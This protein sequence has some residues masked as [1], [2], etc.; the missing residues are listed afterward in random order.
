M[1]TQTPGTGSPTSRAAAGPVPP[2]PG[3][4]AA[5]LCAT[6]GVEH[7]P[8]ALPAVCA[9]CADDR[10]WVPA[11][12]Q[13][14]TTLGELRA[15]GAA[16]RPA[17]LE[18]GLWALPVRGGVG[19][20]Q[21]AKV[22]VTPAGNLMVDVPAYV[23]EAAVAAVAGLGGLAGIIASH[24]HMYGVQS[25]WSAA[26]GNA[27][28]YVSEPDAGWPARR[29]PN[30]VRWSGTLEPLPGVTASQPGGHFPGSVVV[31]FTARDG[32]GVLLA[33]D[34]V[35]VARD[36]AWTTFMRSFPNYLPLSGRVAL[37]I[38][39]HLDRY[40]YDRLYDNFTGCIATD[41]RAVVHRSARRHADWAEGRCDHLT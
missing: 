36:R 18:P 29:P 14:W 23:D 1:D 38:A 8:A 28:V 5:V 12:G 21:H 32:R 39:E 9:V 2:D 37:R 19:I 27:P 30:P 25:E 15:G 34:T 31:H 3:R 13:R 26:F 33:G 7:D 4:D 41:A 20:G 10:Q 24:P 35:G 11:D 6:C 22:L 16:I 40:D 17:E